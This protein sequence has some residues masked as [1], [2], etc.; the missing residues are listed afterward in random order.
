MKVWRSVR[1]C[2]GVAVMALSA[3]CAS[4]PPARPTPE[5]F[6][7]SL[8]GHYSNAGQW[9]QMT[10]SFRATAGVVPVDVR[11]AKVSPGVLGDALVYEEWR[12]ADASKTVLRQ[13]LWSV[14]PDGQGFRADRYELRNPARFAGAGSDAFIGLTNEDF[15]PLGA[16]CALTITFAAVDAWDARTAPGACRPDGREPANARITRAAS[17]LLYAETKGDADPGAVATPFDLRR[18]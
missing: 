17:G 16:W 11:F 14:R 7:A 10:E 6:V 15:R 1:I 13:R 4:S 12:A 8:A 5:R 3:A 2:F 9:A 18:N